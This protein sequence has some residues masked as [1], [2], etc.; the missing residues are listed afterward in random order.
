MF[1]GVW[2][3]WLVNQHSLLHASH[4]DRTKGEEERKCASL[5]LL[6]LCRRLGN[7]FWCKQLPHSLIRLY[8]VCAHS[9]PLFLSL[10]LSVRVSWLGSLSL[11]YGRKDPF[12]LLSVERGGILAPLGTRSAQ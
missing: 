2:V 7:A 11:G 6:P 3:H 10:T 12:F 1:V 9:F 8:L 5:A 4:K